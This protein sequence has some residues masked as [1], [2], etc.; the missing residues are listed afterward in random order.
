MQCKK[1][2]A[3]MKPAKDMHIC[4]ACG[5]RYELDGN[6]WVF[7]DD[8]IRLDRKYPGYKLYNIQ[9]FFPDVKKQD[10]SEA[11][12]SPQKSRPPGWGTA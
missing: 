11:S 8:W 4:I 3:V 1:C 12:H 10:G 5:G 6:Q 7:K 9:F 2:G